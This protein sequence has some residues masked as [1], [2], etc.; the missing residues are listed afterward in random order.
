VKKPPK[1]HRLAVSLPPRW[2]RW[3][4]LLLSTLVTGFYVGIV[5]YF[6]YGTQEAVHRKSMVALLCGSIGLF[7]AGYWALDLLRWVV[8]GD[9]IVEISRYPVPAGANLECFVL[10]ARDHS[11]LR[12][13]QARIVC[14]RQVHRG[15]IQEIHALPLNSGEW[16]D[17][18]GRR[19][20]IQCRVDLPPDA[21]ASL[22]TEPLKIRWCVEVKARF[23]PGFVFLEEHP[24]TVV[25]SSEPSVAGPV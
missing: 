9:T 14:R 4:S 22:E 25:A 8:A 3:S 1:G 23:G 12:E 20:Q 2:P 11:R 10:Q 13:L 21:P 15:E 17:R 6:I 5:Y 24:L 7:C 18:E 16:K 19:F